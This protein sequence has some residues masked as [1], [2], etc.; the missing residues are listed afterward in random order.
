[1]EVVAFTTWKEQMVLFIHTTPHFQQLVN[2]YCSYFLS[3]LLSVTNDCAKRLALDSQEVSNCHLGSCLLG[4]VTHREIAT[5]VLGGGGG[6]GEAR[7]RR[8]I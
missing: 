3:S 5:L 4:V 8:G 2:L 7:Q 6:G 1:M